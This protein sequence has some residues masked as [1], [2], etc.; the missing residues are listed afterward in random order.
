LPGLSISIFPSDFHFFFF[1]ILISSMRA[2]ERLP[3]SRVCSYC[4]AY[5]YFFPLLKIS[6]YSSNHLFRGQFHVGCQ[7]LL[8][9]RGFHFLHPQ[10]SRTITALIVKLNF[11]E[12]ASSR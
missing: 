12:T 10:P 1:P 8:Y 3:R 7:R 5:R 4:S 11:A 9:I 2:K 6:S